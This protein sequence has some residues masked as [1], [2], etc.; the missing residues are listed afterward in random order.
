MDFYLATLL[1]QIVFFVGYFALVRY[2]WL[3]RCKM[4]KIVGFA[5]VLTFIANL[6]MAINFYHN[7]IPT[8][9]GLSFL[10]TFLVVRQ[11][12]AKKENKIQT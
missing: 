12:D 9:S 7:N 3:S 10:L 11:Y 5:V 1:S 6:Y 4:P 2:I 8:L